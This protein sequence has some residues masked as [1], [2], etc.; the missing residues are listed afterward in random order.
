ML[1][2]WDPVFGTKKNPKF[3]TEQLR[4]EKPDRF[5]FTLEPDPAAISRGL[6]IETPPPG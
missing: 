6:K 5:D 4:S 1:S 2:V 3:D